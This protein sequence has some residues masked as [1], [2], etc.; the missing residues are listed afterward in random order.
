MFST[1]IGGDSLIV[2]LLLLRLII[3]LVLCRLLM[4]LVPPPSP[5]SIQSRPH[6]RGGRHWCDF[7]MLYLHL[8]V[9]PLPLQLLLPLLLPLQLGHQVLSARVKSHRN[10]PLRSS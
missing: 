8:R 1:T 10:L 9:L 6:C 5:T 3:R 7:L 2:H 4:Y